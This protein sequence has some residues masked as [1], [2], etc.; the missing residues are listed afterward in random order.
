MNDAGAGSW[1]SAM[2][3]GKNRQHMCAC[4]HVQSS[5]CTELPLFL[6]SLHHMVE[7]VHVYMCAQCNKQIIIICRRNTRTIKDDETIYRTMFTL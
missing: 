2:S 5:H 6:L 7:L 4:V 3:I 1:S